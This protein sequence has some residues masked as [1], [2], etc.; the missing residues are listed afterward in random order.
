MPRWHLRPAKPSERTRAAR[1][2][3]PA[4]MTTAKMPR[5]GLCD[6]SAGSA[7]ASAAIRSGFMTVSAAAAGA[8][9]IAR[10]ILLRFR[11]NGHDRRQSRSQPCRLRRIVERDLDRHALHHLREIPGRIV[12]WQERELRSAGGC[13]LEDAAVHHFTGIHVDADVDRIANGDIRQ[14]RLAKVR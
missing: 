5:S 13:D 3:M 7:E 10:S 8:F 12:R 14:L 11:S 9:D 2:P 4:P 6:R 1:L